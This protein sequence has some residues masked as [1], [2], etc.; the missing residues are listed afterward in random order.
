VI[1]RVRPLLVLV[2]RL[3]CASAFGVSTLKGLSLPVASAATESVDLGTALEA[4]GTTLLVFGTYPADF[5]MI[6]YAQKLTHYLPELREKGVDRVLCVANGQPSSCGL[7]ADLVGLPSDVELLADE[8]GEAGRAFGVSRGWLPET[9]EIAVGD[10]LKVPLSPYA[11][12]FGMLVGLGAWNTLPS[13][14]T[15]YIGNPGGKNGWIEKALAQGQVAG[16][17]PDIALDVEA[18]S[19]RVTRN[20]FDELPLVGGWGRRPLEL[21]TLRLQTMIGVS[22]ARW[23]ELQPTDDRCLTQ[24]GGLLCVRDGATLYEYR[25]NGICATCDFEKLV[26]ALDSAPAASTSA[27]PTEQQPAQ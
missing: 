25:D 26:E 21:A 16:R 8:A 15:G 17:W 1:M 9:S 6:E 22:L 5:N 20:A 12:L 19:G 4:P 3:A 2:A 7:L 24:L 23:E 11:K 27:P 14:I 18:G 13:V 10:E